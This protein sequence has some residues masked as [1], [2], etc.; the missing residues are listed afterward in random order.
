MSIATLVSIVIP[1]YQAAPFLERCL[2]S[3]QKQSHRNVEVIVVDQQSADATTAIAR[4][5]GARV[6]TLPK[7]TFY[8]P[9][10]KSRNAGARESKGDILYHL[11]S[12][13]ELSSALVEEIV[14]IFAADERTG[15]LIVHEENRTRGFWSK[16][17]AFER[18]CY[19][20]NDR[21]ESARVVRR[22]IF[23]AVG[24]YDES[25]SSGEDFDIQKRY[26]EVASV[27][28]CSNVVY[29]DLRLLSLRRTLKKKFDYGKSAHLYFSKRPESATA[30]V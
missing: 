27:G 25:I 6:V 26:Q 17:K 8:S 3:I 22:S 4:E 21:I 28:F 5:F 14:K 29:H 15:A 11:D 30:I 9:P 13:M 16:A 7:P 1:T 20:G 23:E 19:W 2:L 24:G 18:R 12:D 10:T